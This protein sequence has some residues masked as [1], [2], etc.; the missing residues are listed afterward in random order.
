MERVNPELVPQRTLSN[1][2]VIPGIGMGTFG[3]DKYTSE[4][5]SNAVYGAIQA[6]YRLFDCAAAYGNEK[7]IGTVFSKAFSEGL[8]QR[9]DLT[10][11]T[12][13]WN[14]MHG[15]GDVLVAC[16]QSLRDLGLSYLDIYMVHWPYPNY[17]AP[18]AHLEGRNPDAVPFSV[19]EY[20]G[21]WRQMERLVDLG[22]VKSIGMS[23]MTITKLKQ[24]LPLCRIRPTVLEIE[25]NPTFQQPKLF[26]Y[27]KEQGILPIAFSPLG[28]PCRPERDTEPDDVVTFE[29]PEL[30]E[31]AKAH[32]CH[33][34]TICVKWAVQRGQVPIPFSI[35]E[36]EYV[37]NLKCT[38]E[39]FLTKDE[40]ERLKKADRN[41][42]LIKGKVFLWEEAKDW[43]D[44]WDGE[45]EWNEL[46]QQ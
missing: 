37:G 15:K 5:V 33:P 36:N 46:K 39:D 35:Y 30:K 6:G 9:Q 28:S 16:A 12:K 26:D 18:G 11:M 7:D 17:H 1:K 23:N 43:R 20:M 27:C 4:E 41:Q 13:V 8:V 14:D 45:D 31:I 2:M 40:M 32:G 38:T 22:L 3:N 29:L 44:I 10:I 42:R 34:A 19:E 25:I 24:V 21:V